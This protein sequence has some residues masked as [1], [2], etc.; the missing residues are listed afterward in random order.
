[1]NMS[2]RAVPI[3]RWLL[4][5]LSAF[6]LAF[7]LL[8]VPAGAGQPKIYV[9]AVVPS[10]P[11]VA[12]HAAWTPF[13]EALSRESGIGIS[14]K[15]YEKMSDFET[16]FEM[17]VPDLIFASPTQI[18]LA[19]RAQG[20]IPF[21]RSSKLLAGVLFVRKDSPYQSVKDLEGKEIAF[22]GQRNL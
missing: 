14:L 19:K 13:V 22:V 11:P 18:V 12:I 10:A 15:V 4:R 16:D 7:L 21:V 6:L 5:T 8:P 1:M 20:Y 3:A 17:G 9:L 2:I